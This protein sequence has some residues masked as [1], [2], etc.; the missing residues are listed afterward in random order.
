VLFSERG[1]LM[2]K[3][4]QARL[5]R[6]PSKL[7]QMA[8]TSSRGVSRACRH[9]G[10]SRKTFYKWKQRYDEQ[11]DSGLCDQSRVARVSDRARSK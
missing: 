11:G 5:V 8:A 10:I 1:D 6:L 3:A 2:T 7:M 4:E 9:F